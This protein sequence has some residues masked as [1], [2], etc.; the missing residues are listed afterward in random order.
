MMRTYLFF[1]FSTL[2]LLLWPTG[3]DGWM[4]KDQPAPVQAVA[5]AYPPIAV[6]V[7]A[8]GTVVVE[9]QLR[10]DG[11][12][13]KIQTIEGVGALAAAAEN[14]AGQWKFVGTDRQDSKRSVRLTFVFK[15][16]PRDTPRHELLPMFLP[17][18]RV[19]VRATAR[20]LIDSVNRDPPMSKQSSRSP[21]KRP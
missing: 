20:E 2:V 16:M 14:A 12:V 5:P 9:V 18:Y 13:S 8:A 11:T 3:S 15:I 19:E 7:G 6:T 17:P 4:N 1:A 10:A 21:K